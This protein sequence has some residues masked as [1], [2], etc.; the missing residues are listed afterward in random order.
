MRCNLGLWTYKLALWL[1]PHLADAV[2]VAAESMARQ[3]VVGQV[4]QDSARRSARNN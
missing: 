4:H 3:M 2:V 1:N